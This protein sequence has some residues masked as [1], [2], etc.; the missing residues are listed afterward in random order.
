MG[1]VSLP[2]MV[3]DIILGG[4]VCRA[5]CAPF[6][7]FLIGQSSILGD[8]SALTPF[9]HFSTHQNTQKPLLFLKTNTQLLLQIETS[10]LSFSRFFRAISVK[11]RNRRQGKP[12][13]FFE[14][15]LLLPVWPHAT[16][17]CFWPL[18]HCSLPLLRHYTLSRL[19]TTHS[20]D[21]TEASTRVS[22]STPLLYHG[23]AADHCLTCSHFQQAL[24][25]AM[26]R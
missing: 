13:S 25:Q 16:Y 20:H 15:Q 18:W 24:S 19:L 26:C 10:L 1:R 2:E 21:W 12:P 8:T 5:L 11:R 6:S 22:P 3:A 17:F 4:R 14:S 23:T 9:L 7:S